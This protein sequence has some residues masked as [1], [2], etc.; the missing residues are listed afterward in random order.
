[1]LFELITSAVK[2]KAEE[3]PWPRSRQRRRVN[4]WAAAVEVVALG[5]GRVWS[6]SSKLGELAR[7]LQSAEGFLD[8]CRASDRQEL[9]AFGE[10]EQE[11][12]ERG[13]IGARQAAPKCSE[14]IYIWQFGLT[15]T[16]D[17]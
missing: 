2:K 5:V 3:G 17:Q 9:S 16:R 10:R 13:R 8:S 1:M 12:D 15:D 14:V 4:R 6:E 11:R 7:Q